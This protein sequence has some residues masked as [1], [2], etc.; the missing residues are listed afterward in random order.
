MEA[1]KVIWGLCWDYVSRICVL[2]GA[3]GCPANAG[4]RSG[5]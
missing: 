5:Q 1:T 4:L 3:E 2:P